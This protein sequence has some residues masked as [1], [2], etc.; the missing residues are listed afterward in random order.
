[1]NCE[2]SGLASHEVKLLGSLRGS[3]GRRILD[4]GPTALGQKALAHT[5]KDHEGKSQATHM[6]PENSRVLQSNLEHVRASFCFNLSF[7]YPSLTC[8]EAQL[9]CCPSKQESVF[10]RT[11]WS[12]S[13]SSNQLPNCFQTLS[14]S[15]GSRTRLGYVEIKVTSQLLVTLVHP[16][17]C[18]YWRSYHLLVIPCVVCLT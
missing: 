5:L 10:E 4:S 7:Q 15:R 14:E 2:Q 11:C 8:N 18:Q 9:L 12:I 16:S 13:T 1:M 3:H 17:F 6:V